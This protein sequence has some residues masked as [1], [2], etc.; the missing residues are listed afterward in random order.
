MDYLRLILLTNEL[1]IS[2]A[3]TQICRRKLTYYSYL[4]KSQY[5]KQDD[6]L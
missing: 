2:Y 1:N 4:N 3:I 5:N 6:P